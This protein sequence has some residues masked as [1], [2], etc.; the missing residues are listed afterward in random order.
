MAELYR[1]AHGKE[2]AAFIPV[3]YTEDDVRRLARQFATL[4][5]AEGVMW[6]RRDTAAL[7]PFRTLLDGGKKSNDAV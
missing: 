6:G 3:G 4:E 2:T 1:K 5:G 7:A